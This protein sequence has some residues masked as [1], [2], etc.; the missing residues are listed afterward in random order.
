MKLDLDE[1]GWF[2]K[3]NEI[4]FFFYGPILIP[5]IVNLIF[6]ILTII[7]IRRRSSGVDIVN[8]NI[9]REL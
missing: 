9:G 7:N 5:L 4:L 6:F 8:E 1:G 2:F 3:E